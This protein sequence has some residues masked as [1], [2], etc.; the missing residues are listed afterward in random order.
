MDY[1]PLDDEIPELAVWM[2]Y[3][4][5]LDPDKIVETRKLKLEPP[6]AVKKKGDAGTLSAPP[7]SQTKDGM[8]SDRPKVK[9]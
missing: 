8:F 5:D 9:I 4:E 7:I 2:E 1:E 6:L 3:I